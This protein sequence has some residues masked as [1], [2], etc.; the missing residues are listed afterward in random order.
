M[1]ANFDELIRKLD[2]ISDKYKTNIVQDIKEQFG[3][4]NDFGFYIIESILMDRIRY[5]SINYSLT[6]NAEDGKK[7]IE[8][9]VLYHQFIELK[10]KMC[11]K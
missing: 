6:K 10:K 8:S 7:L 5:G 2:K 4:L 3:N 1:S 9:E 11:P